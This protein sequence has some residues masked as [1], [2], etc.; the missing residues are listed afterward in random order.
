[1]VV[2]GGE[3]V[4]T[5]IIRYVIEIWLRMNVEKIPLILQRSD[6]E[7]AEF[8][9]R[10]WNCAEPRSER[11]LVLLSFGVHWN[12]IKNS[13]RKIPLLGIY[14]EIV[15]FELSSLAATFATPNAIF[16][17]WC[18]VALLLLNP[19]LRS[20]QRQG[21]EGEAP[22]LSASVGSADELVAALSPSL[23][24]WS[25]FVILLRWLIKNPN[26]ITINHLLCAPCFIHS[27]H[28]PTYHPRHHKPP[29]KPHEHTS[30]TDG[31]VLYGGAHELGWLTEIEIN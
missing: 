8:T 4:T 7:G 13:T 27:I 19:R 3:W 16:G 12:R 17:I 15:F 29:L 23:I 20:V 30:I 6:F 2:N 21:L 26:L 25:H 28:L 24:W 1:M 9:D 11:A 5:T 18:Y 14:N 31:V 10:L 22:P